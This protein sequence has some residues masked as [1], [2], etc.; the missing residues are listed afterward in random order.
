MKWLNFSA[1]KLEYATRNLIENQ[2]G[3]EMI[4]NFTFFFHADNVSLFGWS[5]EENTTE[6]D[7]KT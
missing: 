3:L 7:G 6:E 1:F 5:Y 2:E 4:E